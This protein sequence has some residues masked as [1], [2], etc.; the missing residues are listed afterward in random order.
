MK[1]RAIIILVFAL[2]VGLSVQFAS[3]SKADPGY[4]ARQ[5]SPRP[6]QVV[7]PGQVVKVEWTAKLPNVNLNPCEAEVFLSL[8]GGNTYIAQISPWLDAKTRSFYWTV[9]NRPTNQAVL[10]IRFGCELIYP[11]SYSPQVESMFVIASSPGDN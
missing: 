2:A 11:E 10:N 5:I 1:V 9:P 3:A 6:G 7:Y 4:S 8:D